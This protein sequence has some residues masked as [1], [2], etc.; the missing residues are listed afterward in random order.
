[1]FFRGLMK[2]FSKSKVKSLVTVLF[3]FSAVFST[4]AQ[5]NSSLKDSLKKFI[6]GNLSEKTQ[7]LTEAKSSDSFE[8]S[9]TA[10]DF[11]INSREILGNDRELDSLAVAATLC[12][13]PEYVSSLNDDGKNQVLQKL[14]TLF[15][16][17]NTSSTVRIA[18]ISKIRSL[19]PYCDV[20]NFTLT[21]NAYLKE[22][23]SYFIETAVTKTAVNA[24]KD[25]GNSE[26]FLVCYSL[27][28][29]QKFNSF[30]DELEETCAVLIPKSMNEV[31]SII[32]NSSMNVVTSLF[33][34]SQKNANLSK[35]NA[36][37]I[38]ENVLLRS[39][40]YMDNFS[41][42]TLE[43]QDIQTLALQILGE[44]RWT[45]ASQTAVNYFLNAKKQ[46]E[47]QNMVDIHFCSVINRL[48]EIAPIDSVMP[49]ASYLE[50]L[51]RQTE[52][53][54]KVSTSVVLSVIKT[55]GSIGDKTAFDSLLAVTYLTY[56]E[57]VLSCAREALSGLRWQ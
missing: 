10:I 31:I 13:S 41:A 46:F 54:E 56:P 22:E 9:Q 17:F 24:L 30:Y 45:R 49:L 43:Q 35:N 36:C 39:I 51:N 48:G 26:S 28:N 57:S 12:I 32:S 29:N 3:I 1:M 27:L 55:L 42:Q 52:N 21:L 11:C 23:E 20:Q 7:V 4:S 14:E 34:L 19:S 38:A 8:L 47:K 15:S 16:Q 44:N 6:R 50:E 40:L 2:Y 25:I 37:E 33:K 5:E 53:G 18:V